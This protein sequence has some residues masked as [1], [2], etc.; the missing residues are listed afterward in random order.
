MEVISYVVSDIEN[1]TTSLW[2]CDQDRWL[3]RVF[4]R[5]TGWCV[6][7]SDLSLLR[8]PT[9]LDAILDGKEWLLQYPNRKGGRVQ[10]TWPLESYAEWLMQVDPDSSGAE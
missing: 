1:G 6:E 7:L 8:D 3:G 5:D 10:A 2:L 9:I 4:E